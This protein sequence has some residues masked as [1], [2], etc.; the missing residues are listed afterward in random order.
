MENG[1]EIADAEEYFGYTP[2]EIAILQSYQFGVTD[3]EYLE[4]V[5]IST[6]TASDFHDLEIAISES[7]P[8]CPMGESFE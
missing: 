8:S 4:F 5:E 6:L 3:S 2:R 7:F 1:P